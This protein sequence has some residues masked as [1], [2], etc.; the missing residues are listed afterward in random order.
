MHRPHETNNYAIVK[1]KLSKKII[2][3]VHAVWYELDSK[4]NKLDLEVIFNKYNSSEHIHCSVV[5]VAS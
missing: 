1:H 5:V 4:H 2:S 3:C